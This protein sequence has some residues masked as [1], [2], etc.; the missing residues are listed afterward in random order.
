MHFDAAVEEENEYIFQNRT[1]NLL[2]SSC[3][4][5]TC[6]NPVNQTLQNAALKTKKVVVTIAV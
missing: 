2:F 4:L 3:F 6:N 1:R 5:N